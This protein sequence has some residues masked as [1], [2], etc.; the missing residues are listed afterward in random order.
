MCETCSR[1]FTRLYNLKSHIRSHQGLR[2]FNCKTCDASFTRNHDLNSRHQRTHVNEKPYT[3]PNCNKNFSRK[4]ALRR[5]QRQDAT[6]KKNVC[7]PQLQSAISEQSSVP[8]A[9]IPELIPEPE[10]IP[11]P[12]LNSQSELIEQ[13][14]IQPITSIAR[15]HGDLESSSPL[16]VTSRSA[17]PAYGT[18][19][20]S[21]PSQPPLLIQP[22]D[23]F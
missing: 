2:P 6:G 9:S 23:G 18:W 22:R 16:L 20:A 14:D 3:C 21:P 8:T 10:H 4:D 13:P 5:H 17:L 12:D 11:Q 7:I 15:P 19:T 1:I